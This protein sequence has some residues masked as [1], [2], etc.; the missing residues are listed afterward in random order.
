MLIERARRGI[1]V[2]RLKRGDPFLRRGGEEA[3][4]LAAAGVPFEIVPG[5]PRRWASRPTPAFRYP[6]RTHVG[7][8]VCDRA[9]G[10]GDRLG[11]GGA[12]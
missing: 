7:G 11:Q 4:A 8:D 12:R 6:S 5:S 1:T 2:V 3:E 9:R 10:S